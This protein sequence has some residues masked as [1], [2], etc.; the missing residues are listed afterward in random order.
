ML[1]FM[2]FSMIRD[3]R[4]GPFF[5]TQFLGAFN[6]NLLK[7]AVTLAVTYNDSLRGDI[8]TGLLINLISAL[9]ILPFFIFSATSGQLADKY[10]KTK[11]MRL[12]KWL[13]PPIVLLTGVGFALNS[14][15]ILTFAVFLLGAQSAFFGPAKYAYLPEHLKSSEL[16]MANA[17]V[18]TGTFM[19][20]LLGTIAAGSILS[21]DAGGVVVYVVCG[22]GMLVALLGV[23]SIHKA[24]LTQPRQPDLK[25]NWNIFS[26]TWHNIKAIRKIRSVWPSLLGIS[27]LWF[28]GATYLT[29]FPLLSKTVLNASSGVA[30]FL[31]FTFTVGLGIGAFVCEKLS[32]KRIEPGL[33]VWGLVLM[34]GSG[35]G[36]HVLLANYNHPSL[37]Q[38]FVGFVSQPKH[39]GLVAVFVAISAGIGLYS[40]PLYTTMQ[41]LSPVDSRSRVVAANNIINS[42]FMVVSAGVA[43]AILVVSKGQVVWVFTVVTVLNV[44]VLV[45]WVWRQPQALMRA[46]LMLK[47]PARKAPVLEGAERLSEQGAFLLVFPSLLHDE[48][49]ARLASLPLRYSVVLSGMLPGSTWVSWLRKHSFVHEFTKLTEPDAQRN[50]V[51]KIAGEIQA[52]RSIAIDK[53]MFN[54]LT[55]KFKLSELPGLLKTKG[56]LM[57][58]IQVEEKKLST[59]QEFSR[60]TLTLT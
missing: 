57:H 41:A 40:V 31:L 17:M 5:W 42:F 50:L 12:A 18:E 14:V 24:P 32:H 10:D 30:T 49:E 7:F 34:V 53:A 6:D 54:L 8:S 36:L 52:G 2:K 43:V 38:D 15:W 45:L 22:F 28:V 60:Q 29:Q 56:V 1:G 58:I 39:W 26:E 19:A 23:Y 9:F 46:I 16:V 44:A 47:V 25:V 48:F 59:S 4:F 37:L 20:I 21:Q 35:V 55:Q 27:W 3:K 33:I 13:E 11:V 51:K